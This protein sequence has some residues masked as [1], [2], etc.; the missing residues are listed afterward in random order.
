VQPL[1]VPR[2]F[3]G[4]PESGNGGWVS[5]RIAA[6]LDP[7][8]GEAVR[9][10]LRSPPPL[11]VPLQVQHGADGGLSVWS[12]DAPVAS[13]TRVP[14]TS[15]APPF[16]QPAPAAVPFELAQA[17]AAGYAGAQDHPFPSCFVCG[18]SRREG[19]GLRLAPGRLDDRPSDTA[20]AWVPDASLA[21]GSSDPVDVAAC[22]AALDCPGGWALDLTGRPMVLGTMTALV[23]T[24]PRVGGRYVVIGRAVGGPGDATSS[25]KAYT[26]TALYDGAAP[27]LPLARASAVWLRVDPAAVRPR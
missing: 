20:A 21:G 13:A 19:D 10:V 3:N 15:A 6:L 27:G 12:G 16:A 4:P 22:W 23:R 24:L 26:E 11:E 2:R 14:A 18:P 8:A 9:V 25:R 7:A 1:V 5:G 17:A